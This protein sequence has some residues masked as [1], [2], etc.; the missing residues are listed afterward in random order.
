MI[1]ERICDT[2]VIRLSVNHAYD[3]AAMI[4][5]MNEHRNDALARLVAFYHEIV[6]YLVFVFEG[7]EASIQTVGKSV[8]EPVRR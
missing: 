2:P 3:I 7:V 5:E 4:D 8:P 6:R 1:C